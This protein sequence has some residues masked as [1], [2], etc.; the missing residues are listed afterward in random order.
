[1]AMRESKERGL[2]AGGTR[3]DLL[4]RHK[5]VRGPV[6]ALVGLDV[7]VAALACGRQRCDESRAGRK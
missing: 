2:E 4:R 1:M 6:D 5:R 7:A 3:V